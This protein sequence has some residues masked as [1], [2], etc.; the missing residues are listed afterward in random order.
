[1]NET[2]YVNPNEFNPKRFLNDRGVYVKSAAF[3]PFSYGRRSC[4]GDEF[5]L[6][7]LFLSLA[8]FLQMTRKYTII[9]SDSELTSDQLFTTLF[10]PIIQMPQK[11]V[12]KFKELD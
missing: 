1:M 2:N 12:I 10:F 6:N 3:I 5:A 7:S 11:F 4:I 8:N 9:L